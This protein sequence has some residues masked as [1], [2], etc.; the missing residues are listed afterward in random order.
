MRLIDIS[1][2]DTGSGLAGEVIEWTE[3][4]PT[5]EAIPIEWL[6]RFKRLLTED[7]RRGIGEAISQW[8]GDEEI[9]EE[10]ER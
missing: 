7:A 1:Y 9:I 6:E 3:L 2:T 4:M 10:T 8:N 5:V